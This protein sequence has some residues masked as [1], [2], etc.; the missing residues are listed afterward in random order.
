MKR[1]KPG[2][3]IPTDRHPVID[4][5]LYKVL[6]MLMKRREVFHA[7]L[8]VETLDGSYRWSAAAGDADLFDRPMTTGTPWFVSGLDH[9]FNTVIAVKLAERDL[10][11]FDEPIA[12]H[13]DP[14]VIRGLHV[15]DGRD[16]TEEITVRNLLGHS[17]GLAD[18]FEDSPRGALSILD[19]ALQ[20]G[21]RAV[22][23]D[24]IRAHLRERLRPHFPPQNG[25]QPKKIRYSTTNSFL[26]GL[27]LE[28]VTGKP[29]PE[30]HR[31]LL[32]DSLSLEQTFF[33]DPDA[34]PDAA[35]VADGT[36]DA[37][38]VADGATSAP[39][40]SRNPAAVHFQGAPVELPRLMHSLGGLCSTVDDTIMFMRAVVTGKIFDDPATAATMTGQ[41]NRF[42]FPLDRTAM[43]QPAWPIE[44][45]LGIM[46][47]QLRR[48]FTP[49]SLMP[50][51]VGHTGITGS[52]LLWSP[53]RDLL[54]SGT[55]DEFT[56]G[57]LPFQTIVPEILRIAALK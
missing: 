18:W 28:A 24:E 9:F 40:V 2:A 52:W 41:W 39:G 15:M 37:A 33:F 12:R 49:R 3:P 26:L 56:A 55:V 48:I 23:R 17:S 27:V 31:E 32:H 1:R 43:R 47:F 38:R 30:V 53:E 7:V 22:S 51:V 11:D 20:N 10:I 16:A 50:S 6:E 34:E 25:W 8:A 46:R 36:T 21:D 14:E 19:D 44:Y 35:R 57:A 29:L 4:K 45:G 54:L 42:P 5:G 13:L